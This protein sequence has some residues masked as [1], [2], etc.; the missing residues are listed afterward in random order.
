MK[1]KEFVLLGIDSGVEKFDIFDHRDKGGRE[2]VI[3]H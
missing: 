2:Q 1:I 3:W